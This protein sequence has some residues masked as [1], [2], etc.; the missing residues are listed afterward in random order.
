MYI[1]RYRVSSLVL[2]GGQVTLSD[3]IW[4]VMPAVLR[5]GSIK[6]STLFNLI[7]VIVRLCLSVCNVYMPSATHL[8]LATA[9]A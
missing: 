8:S 2:G 9:A 1:L 5:Q 3:P 4:Q 6:S 7:K